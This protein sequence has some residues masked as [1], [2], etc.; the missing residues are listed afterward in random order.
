MDPVLQY[1]AGDELA[2]TLDIELLEYGPGHAKSRMKI[3]QKHL[4]GMHNVHGGSIFALADFTFAVAANAHGTVAVAI[5]ADISFVKGVVLGATL[6]A[7]GVEQTRNPKIGTYS[8]TVTDDA[9][10]IVALFTG[11]VYRKKN[12]ITE[13]I[14]APERKQE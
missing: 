14:S 5:N 4:N 11:M 8:I 1:F 7:E 2:K 9:G 12:L 6:I 3:S 10:D 13:Y